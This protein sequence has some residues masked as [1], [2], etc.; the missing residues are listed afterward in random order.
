MREYSGSK[1]IRYRELGDIRKELDAIDTEILDL[2]IKRQNLAKEVA[3]YKKAN[4]VPI[5]R[6]ERENEILGRVRAAAGEE[7]G[8]AAVSLFEELLRSSRDLQR[9]TADET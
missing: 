9:K 5:L 2:F 1:D 7:Y 3:R 6:P 8:S 4:N